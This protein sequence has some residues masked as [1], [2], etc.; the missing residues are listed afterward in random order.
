MHA[1]TRPLA[2]THTRAR[3]CRAGLA[4]ITP[5]F[6][7]YFKQRGLS[8]AQ[9]GVI[10]AVRQWVSVPSSFLWSA[11]ADRLQRHQAILTAVLVASTASRLG[12]VWASGFGAFL[13]LIIVNQFVTSPVTVMADAIV[14]SNCEQDGDY[15]KIRAW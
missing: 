14:M 15:G 3:L 6:N 10:S 4:S 7:V 12:L 9:V 1:R 13:A 5:Y 2:P 11:A 8:D